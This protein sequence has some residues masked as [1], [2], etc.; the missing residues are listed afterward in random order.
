MYQDDNLAAGN[1]RPSHESHQEKPPVS[2]Y[3]VLH[4]VID[5]DDHL[6]GPELCIPDSDSLL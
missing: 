5:K 1:V 6:N 2:G 3:E 4:L